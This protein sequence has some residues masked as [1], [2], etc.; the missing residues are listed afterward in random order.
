[1]KCQRCGKKEGEYLCSVCNRVVCSDCKVMDKGK[2]YCADHVPKTVAPP[3]APAP[4]QAPQPK[5]EPAILKILK[6]LIYS[7]LILLIGI[8]IIFAI[9]NYFIADLL[10]SISETASEVFPEL[11][12]VFVLLTYFESGGL[13][14]IIFLFIIVVLLIIIYKLKKRSYKNI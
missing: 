6:E 14:A 2:V 3:Q 11:D 8:I 9:S 4:T 13:Y 7:F 12:F 5:I 10:S 1:M